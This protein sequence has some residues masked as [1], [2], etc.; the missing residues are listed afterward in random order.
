MQLRIALGLLGEPCTQSHLTVFAFWIP[1][2]CLFLLPIY[3]FLHFIMTVTL[4][5]DGQ[6]GAFIAQSSGIRSLRDDNALALALVRPR[7]PHCSLILTL[8]QPGEQNRTGRDG[9]NAPQAVRGSRGCHLPVELLES[10]AI[11]GG[12]CVKVLASEAEQ[13]LPEFTEVPV[14][15]DVLFTSIG[16]AGEKTVYLAMMARMAWREQTVLM[17]R[18]LLTQHEVPLEEGAV[19]LAE[20]SRSRWWRRGDY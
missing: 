5:V 11:D 14:G 4:S 13:L 10:R 3:G 6:D 12:I 7:Q 2:Q 9:R 20:R 19:T 1:V 8:R 15:K 16:G 17:L 18:K